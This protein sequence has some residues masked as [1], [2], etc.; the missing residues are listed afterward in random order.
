MLPGEPGKSLVCV[1]LLHLTT[2]LTTFFFFFHLEEQNSY[3]AW[4]MLPEFLWPTAAFM[5]SLLS[6]LNL[7]QV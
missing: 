5:D 2:H 3:S 4:E 1:P 6:F 7:I